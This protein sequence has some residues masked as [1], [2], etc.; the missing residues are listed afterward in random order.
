MEKSN[1]ASVNQS[2]AMH[3]WS[4]VSFPVQWFVVREMTCPFEKD[5]NGV[6]F[7]KWFL[8]FAQ[9]WSSKC[10]SSA[11]NAVIRTEKLQ[12]IIFNWF[13]LSRDNYW[14][15]EVEIVRESDEDVESEIERSIFNMV[16]PTRVGRERLFTCPV[17]W[18]I[19][20]FQMN[21]CTCI[22]TVS[23]SAAFHLLCACHQFPA[24]NHWEWDLDQTWDGNWDLVYSPSGPSY[25]IVVILYKYRTV[26][27]LVQLLS[28]SN[29]LF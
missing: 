28:N 21:W 7:K 8:H 27:Q 23:I 20:S 25:N 24:N 1:H 10:L 14:R 11:N 29:T 18:E 5:Q 26:V 13:R 22:Q 17:E 2:T 3:E 16:M 4:S 6:W 12:T 15:G 19:F 9:L